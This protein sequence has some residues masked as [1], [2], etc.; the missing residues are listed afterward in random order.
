MNKCNIKKTAALVIG[1]FIVGC[2]SSNSGGSNDNGTNQGDAA[3]LLIITP[4]QVY[5]NSGSSSGYVVIKNPTDTPVS[6]VH[7]EL[8]NLVGGA[9]GASI[10]ADSEKSCSV[11]AANSECRIEI[12]IPA[13]AVAGSLGFSASNDDSLLTKLATLVTVSEAKTIGIEETHYNN[14]S[15]ADG[16]VVSYYEKIIKGVPY[17]L[18]SG[19]VASKNAGVFNKI[20]LVDSVGNPLPNQE[21]ISGVVVDNT[22]GSTFSILIPAPSGVGV[23]QSLRLQTRQDDVVVDTSSSGHTL[24]VVAGGAVVEML[25]S[26]IYLTKDHPRQYVTFS[27]IGDATAQLKQMVADSSNISVTF[28]PSSLAS[29]KAITA[30]LEMEST[31]VPTATGK[32]VDLIYSGTTGS[33]EL[34]SVA[35]NENYYPPNNNNPTPSAYGL[36]TDLNPDNNFYT[37]TALGVASRQMTI[38]NVGNTVESNITLTLPENFT[39]SAGD[40]SSTS[41]TVT[42][43]TTP[44][45]ISDNLAAR[46]GSCNLTVSYTNHTATKQTGA[47]IILH[48]QYNNGVNAPLPSTAAV[49][50]QVLQSSANLFLTP[51]V[52]QFYGLLL[53]DNSAIS[54]P[55]TF[56]L[57][58]S[59]DVAASSLALDNFA[60][61]NAGLFSVINGGDN[62]CVNGGELANTL[63][64]NSCKIVTQFGPAPNGSAGNKSAS[65]SVG[66]LPYS[67]GS[68][69]TTNSV[70]LSGTVTA[71]P[72]ASFSRTVSDDTF[73]SGGGIQGNPYLGIE[74]NAY[75]LTVTYT[76]TSQITANSF[77]TTEPDLPV[78][79]ILKTHGCNKVSVN[80]GGSCNDLYELQNTAANGIYN[81][82]LENVD[83]SWSDSSG[84]YSDQG[85]T[86]VAKVYVQLLPPPLTV[87]ISNIVGNTGAMMGTT[88]ITFTATID[89]G[90]NGDSSTISASLANSVTGTIVSDPSPCILTVGG[91]VNNCRFSI[92]PWYT[93]FANSIVGITNQDPFTPPDT[94]IILAASNEAIFAGIEN[95]AIAYSVITPYVYLPQTGQDPTNDT[96]PDADGDYHTGIPWAVA[97][98]GGTIAPNP[99]F[100]AINNGEC[101]RDNLTKLIWVSDVTTANTNPDGV[102]WTTAGDIAAAGTWCGQA[103]GSWR[104]PNINEMLTLINYGVITTTNPSS[105]ANW[106]MYGSGTRTQP[107]CDGACFKNVIPSETADPLTFWTST[108]YANSVVNY[109]K[110]WYVDFNASYTTSTSIDDPNGYL[111]PVR[112]GE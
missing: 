60:G 42:H 80:A 23:S 81:L 90:V 8:T 61:T 26:E 35:V 78:G 16:I 112:G 30:L 6:N 99:R 32:E 48:Y 108:L 58:N 44:A 51:S 63:D 37:T 52:D 96:Y 69:Q 21:L 92:I 55:I 45:T 40:D 4:K 100:E 31:G 97:P 47:D 76:N 75:T 93:G 59:G 56:T 68:T 64:N 91:P 1:C 41:C 25:P 98:T 105:N 17:V 13:G 54:A 73:T 46:T 110:A 84:T 18:V 106:L 66:Y 7:Y 70:D 43:A 67:G 107:N 102:D 109:T 9:N 79:Y 5:S 86:G 22:Q 15:G 111:F 101:I 104:L 3:S 50:Y 12:R 10:D 27:N 85:V 11:V 28:K 49:D 24:T 19:L 34:A 94:K 29:G 71:A 62:S 36:I 65:Y 77:T 88:P 83:V 2:S 72:S 53:S 39:I 89:G 82:P 95:N 87:T 33:E 20:I 103:A 38:T 74:G 57:T 14:L